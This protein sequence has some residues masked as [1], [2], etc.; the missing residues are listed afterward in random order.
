MLWQTH[1]FFF[2]DVVRTTTSGIPEGGKGANVPGT[3]PG[4]F[5]PFWGSDVMALLPVPD[6][7]CDF[8]TPLP[9]GRG[10]CCG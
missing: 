1:N 5:A 2:S 3:M 8:V 6:A 7:S 4:T 9:G 10:V